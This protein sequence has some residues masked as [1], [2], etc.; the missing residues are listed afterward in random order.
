M[1][2]IVAMIQL[3]SEVAQH[4]QVIMFGGAKLQIWTVCVAWL[5]WACSWQMCLCDSPLP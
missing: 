3:P 1:S 5:V 4:V 2:D